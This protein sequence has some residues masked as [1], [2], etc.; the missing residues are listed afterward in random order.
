MQISMLKQ[1]IK[2]PSGTY[3]DFQLIIMSKI[4]LIYKGKRVAL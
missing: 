4:N 1:A 2:F 3:E